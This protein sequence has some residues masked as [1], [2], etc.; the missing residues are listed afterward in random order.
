MYYLKFCNSLKFNTGLCSVPGTKAPT[1]V[2]VFAFGSGAS[3]LAGAD[4]CKN[5]S[6]EGAGAFEATP[7]QFHPQCIQHIYTLLALM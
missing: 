4:K 7:Q 6:A 1:I 5:L 3:S 2:G